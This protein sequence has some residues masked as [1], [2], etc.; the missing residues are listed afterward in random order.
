MNV[1][2]R[3]SDPLRTSDGRA[4][5]GR[6]WRLMRRAG[7][8]MGV[9]L[10][11]VVL[12]VAPAS[13][14]ADLV[15]ASPAPGASLSQAPA[16]VLR[17]SEI[18]NPSLST[19]TVTGPAGDA[20]SGPTPVLPGNARVMQRPLALLRPGRYVVR[21][22]SVASDD[23]HT[24]NGSYGFAVAAATA[25]AQDL[26]AGAV[27]AAGPLGLDG[28]LFGFA[29]LVLWVGARVVSRPCGT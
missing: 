9:T 3:R 27:T 8:V 20:T 19:I 24:L 16:V 29:G 7:A 23:G 17:F 21:W 1:L 15:S 11:L 5:T 14:H 6:T 10:V 13:A 25:A 26:D 22:A 28:P 12:W 18:L 2:G 4:R